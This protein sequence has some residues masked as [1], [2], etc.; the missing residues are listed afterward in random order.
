MNGSTIVID[1][2][3]QTNKLQYSSDSGKWECV[4]FKCFGQGSRW[5]FGREDCNDNDPTTV[6]DMVA[7]VL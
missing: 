5:Y 1:P 3:V 4:D 6:N 7:M 2:V